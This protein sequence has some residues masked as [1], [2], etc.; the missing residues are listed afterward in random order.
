MEED[1]KFPEPIWAQNSLNSLD[2]IDI[3]FPSDEDIIEAMTGPEWPWE[4]MHHQSYFLPEI[5]RTKSR[6]LQ[7]VVS[8]TVDQFVNPFVKHGIY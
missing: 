1:N 2:Y 6:K 7:S 4:D 3:V 5:N 8:R